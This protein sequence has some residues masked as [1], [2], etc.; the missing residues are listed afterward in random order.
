MPE[1][2]G[3]KTPDGVCLKILPEGNSHEFSFFVDEVG[4]NHFA[5][6][7]KSDSSFDDEDYNWDAEQF[8][9]RLASYL[10]YKVE[11]MFPENV[12]ES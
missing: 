9:E 2:S 10:G 4:K 3:I 12:E 6:V 7:N 5:L 8:L 11:K 1:I